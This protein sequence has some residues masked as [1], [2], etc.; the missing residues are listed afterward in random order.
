MHPF[1]RA[2]AS[3]WP[4]YLTAIHCHVVWT[5]PNAQGIAQ[6]LWYHWQLKEGEVLMLAVQKLMRRCESRQRGHKRPLI[7]HPLAY[8]PWMAYPW[9]AY[10]WTALFILRQRMG[11]KC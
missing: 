5:P 2:R 4:H 10:H 7:G 11:P 6:L 1:Q 9:M 3:K 8:H